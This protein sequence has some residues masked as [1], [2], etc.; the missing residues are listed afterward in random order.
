[1][2]PPFPF[3]DRPRL[4]GVAVSHFQVEGNDRCDWTEWEEAGRTAGGPCGRA[5]GSWERDRYEGDLALAR[6]SGANAFRFSVSWSR[7]EPRR[8]EFDRAALERYR[9]VVD[10]AVRLDLEPAVT[11]FHYTHPLWFHR[12]TPWTS[13]LSV[14]AFARFARETA[15]ALGPAARLWTVLNE[16]LVFLLGGFLD[17]RIPPGL[18]DARSAGRALDNLLAAHAAAAAAIREEI[19]GAVISIAHN[20]MEFAADRR[21]HPLERW[22]ASHASRVYNDGLL[23]AFTTGRWDL[24]IPPG[25]RLRGRRDDL[26]SSLDVVGV[27]FYSR[28]HVRVPGTGALPADF[29]YRDRTG[30]GLTDNSWEIVPA[31]LVSLLG[32]ASKAAGG[33]PLLV[34]ENGLADGSDRL[35]GAF[36]EDH[37]AALAEAEAA[38]IPVSGYFHWSLVDNY[39]WLDGWGPKFGLYELDHETLERRERP[40]AA[41]FRELGKEF[42]AR[43]ARLAPARR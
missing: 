42:L 22:L 27:N 30:K 6:E 13:P 40:S 5:A 14:E 20:V 21:W 1:V 41:V 4:W 7:V 26:A 23:E 36:L 25:T 10:E 37:A 15:R 43:S 29:L 18:G 8:G 24:W 9:R 16:P 12:E 17:G 34:T 33:R 2:P 11:L 35:R 28:L 32:R 19:P 31:A 39:E 38:G 3:P